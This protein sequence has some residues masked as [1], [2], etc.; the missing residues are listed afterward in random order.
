MLCLLCAC[1]SRAPVAQSP[2]DL[3]ASA[4]TALKFP[5]RELAGEVTSTTPASSV[6]RIYE[7]TPTRDAPALGAASL[8]G[9]GAK[10]E[11]ELC[12]DFQCPYCAQLAPVVHELQQNYEELLR[13]TWRNCP[14]PFHESA[15]QAAEAALE[16]KA[17]RGDGAFWA[18][19]DLLFTHQA[20]LSQD[21]LI[22]Y[23]RG[24]EGVDPGR[25]RDALADHRHVPHVQQE[26]RALIDSG[27]AAG[28]LGTP[29]AFVNGRMLVGAQPYEK[30]EDAVE[31]ALQ[32]PPEVRTKAEADSKA[33]YPM[34]RV[35][36]ILVEYKGARGAASSVQRS[37]A[38]A[39]VR[40]EQ[41]KKRLSDGHVAFADL[42]RAESDCPS[43]KD[44]GQLGR[45]TQGE[46]EPHLEVALF[47]LEPGQVSEVVTSPFG[48]HIL[49][50]EP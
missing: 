20:D 22:E 4:A 21:K 23:A 6:E 41:L 28:G 25:L 15:L 3:H 43:K 36:H 31:R 1:A 10:V 44:G 35:R 40:A 27:A 7:L 50:R 29:V 18:Y 37:Q 47:M 2:A 49:L 39:Q 8:G 19:H 48:Y 9:A 38:Q 5:G 42:A 14:L 34:A 16:V 32:E 12:S 30:Y 17:Q 24:I 45:F 26:V 33:A 13:I 11:L 46:L